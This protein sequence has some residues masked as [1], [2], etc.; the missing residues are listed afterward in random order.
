LAS[1]LDS[2]FFGSSRHGTQAPERPF[3]DELLSVERLDERAR[4]LAARF[5]VDPSRRAARSVFQRFDD[6]VRLLRE[7]YRT[8]AGDAHRGEFVTAAAEWLLDNFHLVASEIRDIRQNLPRGYYREL[9][10]LAA[11]EQAGN[12]RVYAL[13]VK[14]IRHSDSRLDRPQLVR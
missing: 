12:A 10:K 6:N 11:R 9:P 14:L 1:K 13:A 5:T 3:R 8:L 4:S 7:A 2:A